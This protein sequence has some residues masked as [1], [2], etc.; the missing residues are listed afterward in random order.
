MSYVVFESDS[1]GANTLASYED[2]DAAVNH[3]YHYTLDNLVSTFVIEVGEQVNRV[4]D[5]FLVEQSHCG[6]FYPDFDAEAY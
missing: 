1:D 2:K 5:T 4:V 6:G 3:A